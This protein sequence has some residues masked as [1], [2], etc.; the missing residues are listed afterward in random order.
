MKHTEGAARIPMLE[1]CADSVQKRHELGV[2]AEVR[3]QRCNCTLIVDPEGARVSWTRLP[4]PNCV[5][6]LA[7]AWFHV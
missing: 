3:P 4:A 7:E 5:F 1:V 2:V 6:E